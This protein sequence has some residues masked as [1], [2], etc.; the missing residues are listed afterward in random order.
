MSERETTQT[1]T[2]EC[3]TR[4]IHMRVKTP[5]R[6]R[7]ARMSCRPKANHYLLQSISGARYRLGAPARPSSIVWDNGF[8][9]KLKPRKPT[10]GDYT[11]RVK[12]AA[13]LEIAEK[14]RPD[15]KEALE[16]YRHFLYGGGSDRVFSYESYVM[17][18]R[19]GNHP[20]QRN[21]RHSGWRQGLSWKRPSVRQFSITGGQI[22][23]GGTSL[24][25]Y[26]QTENWQ[27]AIG[28]HVIWLSGGVKIADRAGQ[29]LVSCLDMTLHAE[30]RYNFNPGAKDITTGIPDSDNGI[31]EVT[32]LAKQYTQ[33]ATLR[34]I[35]EWQYGTLGT[36]STSTASIPSRW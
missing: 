19:S 13:Q 21:A 25:P 5:V 17:N 20:R 11:A 14:L 7:A 6:L 1:G 33:T 32:G 26:P 30:D 15:L 10:A 29:T 22:P 36:G 28:G 3:A 24:F 4:E 8:L 18:D 16:A 27:K 35:I 12:W 2:R 9:D 31:F 34:R 23:C